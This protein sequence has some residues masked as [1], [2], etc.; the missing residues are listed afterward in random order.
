MHRIDLDLDA[1]TSAV[2]R[3]IDDAPSAPLGAAIV[4]YAGILAL[5]LWQWRAMPEPIWSIEAAWA[6]FVLWG[7]YLV[8]VRFEER[9]LGRA[10]G[11]PYVDYAAE[12]PRF[13]P[14]L[15]RPSARTTPD[16]GARR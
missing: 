16:L 12:V 9:D 7:R 3:R 13:L 14:R 2:P 4:I 11:Q 1:R 6:R 10:I 8:G 5:L 15:R